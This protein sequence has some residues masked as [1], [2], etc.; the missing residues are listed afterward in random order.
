MAIDPSKKMRLGCE[1]PQFRLRSDARRDH[2]I[3][4][5]KQAD[6]NGPTRVW[7]PATF[8]SKA[9]YLVAHYLVRE[10]MRTIDRDKGAVRRRR[11][12]SNPRDL[13]AVVPAAPR[14]PSSSGPR[15]W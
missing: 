10:R 4:A 7:P 1:H 11:N 6:S 9:E 8:G 14:I 3:G 15:K 5:P 12:G 13:K 2:P